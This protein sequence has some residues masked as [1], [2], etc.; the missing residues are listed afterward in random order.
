MEHLPTAWTETQREAYLRGRRAY[1]AGRNIDVVSGESTVTEPAPC[2]R[3]D[4]GGLAEKIATNTWDN[5]EDFL[6]VLNAMRARKWHW[7]KNHKCKY[8]ELRVDMR[9]GC[10]IIRDRDGNR[11]DPKD[12]AR[13]IHEE[14]QAVIPKDR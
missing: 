3:D 1:S 10:C 8:V 2:R 6:S 9:D 7:W 12:L 5:I 4:V 14:R 13:Q 11:I